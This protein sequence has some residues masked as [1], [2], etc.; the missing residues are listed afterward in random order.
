MLSWNPDITP[1]H[2]RLRLLPAPNSCVP[3]PPVLSFFFVFADLPSYPY[4]FSATGFR[5]AS[6]AI[7]GRLPSS[8]PPLIL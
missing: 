6:T 8:I 3:F 1:L 7:I 4:H 5:F 2:V